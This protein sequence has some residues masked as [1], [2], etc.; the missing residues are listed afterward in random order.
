ME[1]VEK[2]LLLAV[3]GVALLIV[4]VMSFLPPDI[5]HGAGDRTAGDRTAG[6]RTAG[7]RTAKQRPATPDV[8]PE[9]HQGVSDS[10]A[11]QPNAGTPRTLSELM[12]RSAPR[13][14]PIPLG[15]EAA[16][17]EHGAANAGRSDGDAVPPAGAMRAGD[18]A[19][20]AVRPIGAGP[21]ADATARPSGFSP[22]T[23]GMRVA[24]QYSGAPDYLS[25]TV[26]RGDTLTQILED[27]CG[28]QAAL[29]DVLAVNESL[30]LNPNAL[31]PGSK[32]LIPKSAIRPLASRS[33]LRD[34]VAPA[35]RSSRAT[36]AAAP[37]NRRAGEPSSARASATYTVR[38]GDTL[39]RIAAARVGRRNAD[40]YVAK[41]RAINPKARARVLL[42]GTKLRMPK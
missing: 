13:G 9:D 17:S 39:W 42:P 34:R 16:G 19:R 5:A 35:R 25:Y 22:A 20:V 2:V 1:R 36:G 37:A 18:D 4:A 3:L 28:T 30:K 12:G 11:V 29:D 15:G 10:G 21:V 14:E 7:D 41:I 38:G 23:T 32:L 24:M 33:M 26:R 40:K 27:V 31:R 6:D 8:V